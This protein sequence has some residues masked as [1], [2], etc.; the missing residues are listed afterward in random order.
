[1]QTRLLAL[2]DEPGSSRERQDRRDA[3]QAFLAAHTTWVDNCRR[4][5]QRSL[6]P[7]QRVKAAD[8]TARQGGRLE[9]LAEGVMDNQILASRLALRVLDLASTELNELRLRIQSL[10]RL[11]E[12]PRGDV[13][14]PDV[15]T[16]VLVDQWLEVALS[17]EAWQMVQDTVAPLLARHMHEAYKATNQFLIASGVMKQIDLNALVR[18][19]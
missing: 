9:L 12:M 6:L 5:L 1:C 7:P 11:Q 15:T 17:R 3:Y 14:L 10:E 16:R 13:L 8:T 2:M 4:A 18:R 19:A